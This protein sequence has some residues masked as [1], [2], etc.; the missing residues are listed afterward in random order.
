MGSEMCIRDRYKPVYI[1]YDD[2][3]THNTESR[4]TRSTEDRGTGCRRTRRSG[5]AQQH[6]TEE[7]AIRQNTIAK[8]SYHWSS[9][10]IRNCYVSPSHLVQAQSTHL[11][12]AAAFCRAFLRTVVLATPGALLIEINTHNELAVI[13]CSTA[14]VVQENVLR[15]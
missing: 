11:L 10:I 6:A 9:L 12:S 8:P 3:D 7:F 2:P 5:S 1:L 15:T 4:R 14:V 13:Y